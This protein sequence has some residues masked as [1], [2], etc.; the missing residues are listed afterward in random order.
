[1]ASLKDLV[2][3]SRKRNSSSASSS[4][5]SRPRA[6]SRSPPSGS[7]PSSPRRVRSPAGSTNSF[8]HRARHSLSL[9]CLRGATEL[10]CSITHLALAWVARNPNTS[11]V[12]LGASKPEQ[13]LDNL[14]ALEVLPKLT[15]EVLEKIEKILG[16]KPAPWVRHPPP[17][18][19][20]IEL[21]RHARGEIGS[22]PFE[23][24]PRFVS[25]SR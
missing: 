9:P 11:T 19:P 3:E 15:P 4:S 21:S 10:D 7:S 24:Q 22:R 5:S 17:F 6:R 1:M 25:I 20:F 2:S 13:V 8:A 23:S 16:N 12:I 18:P 14:K